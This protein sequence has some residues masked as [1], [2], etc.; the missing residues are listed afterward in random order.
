MQSIV[1]VE[2]SKLM[3]SSEN[4][5]SLEIVIDTSLKNKSLLEELKPKIKENAKKSAAEKLALIESS[6][7]E[8][9]ITD[10]NTTYDKDDTLTG[11]DRMTKKKLI[12]RR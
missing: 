4:G 12:K 3:K 10:G 9:D 7:S 6:S 5:M 8:D 11:L 2:N 1:S